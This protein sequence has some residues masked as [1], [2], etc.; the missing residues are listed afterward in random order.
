MKKEHL[1]TLISLFILWACGQRE[2]DILSKSPL[3]D[4]YTIGPFSVNISKLVL[5]K[6]S[7]VLEKPY[8]RIPAI[9]IANNGNIIAACEKRKAS[10]DK[11]EIDVILA[12]SSDDGNIFTKSILFENNTVTGRK[13]NPNFVVDRTGVHGVKGRIYCFVLAFSNPDKLSNQVDKNETSTL[14]KYSDDNGLS[15]SNEIK[16][17]L[18][19]KYI[20]FGPSPA[21]GIQLENGTL[22]IPAFIT[23]PD[24]SFRTGIIFKVTNGDWQF[25][26][27][28]NTEQNYMDNESTI[29]LYG[30]GN[31]VL[32]NARNGTTTQRHVYYSNSISNNMISEDIV[33]TVHDS[34]Q[35]NVIGA[36]QGSLLAIP[37]NNIY[38]F[39][40]PV[41]AS[42]SHTCIW[43]SPDLI[44]WIPFHSVTT[45]STGGYSA[46]TYYNNQLFI[47]YESN[48]DVTE[49]E[50][51]NLSPIVPYLPD[52]FNNVIAGNQ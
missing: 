51:Q 17:N 20:V 8:S 13:M 46:I 7:D 43:L 30:D 47:I 14:Y 26:C 15:W 38:L 2:D 23:L 12:V 36:C 44:K 31:Q 37:D 5:F 18:P 16:L 29:I 21:N 40:N 6:S 35:F 3:V 19:D 39:T 4:S 32:L 33:W 10:G 27:I 34:A 25:S 41:E 22:V 50:I 49:C 28:N 11:G 1:M 45:E 9:V 52:F 24:K 42:R 48:P